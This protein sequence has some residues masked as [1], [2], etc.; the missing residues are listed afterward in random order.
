[1]KQ[2][3]QR[4]DAELMRVKRP[5]RVGTLVV[6]ARGPDVAGRETA[7][8]LFEAL[9]GTKHD[10]FAIG[11]KAEDSGYLDDLGRS[12]K[13]EA[14]SLAALGPAFEEAARMV[15]AARDRFYL[16]QYCSP[17]R[18]GKPR[19]R[20]EVSYTNSEGHERQ[21][22]LELAFDASGFG[23]GCDP[24]AEP[25]FRVAAVDPWEIDAEPSDEAESTPGAGAASSASPSNP[26]GKSS[27]ASGAAPS[28]QPRDDEDDDSIVPP[29][30]GSGY[31]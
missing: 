27:P 4:L 5:I 24:K 1:V 21:G 20:L 30:D 10:L 29:P 16:V 18:A 28:D 12:G 8:S 7:D 31:E 23:P 15:N 2:A 26:T 3:L 14:A 22:A 17:S 9:D 11:V 6:F 13:S 25:T 19:F